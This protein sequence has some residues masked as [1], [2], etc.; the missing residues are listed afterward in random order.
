MSLLHVDSVNDTPATLTQRPTNTPSIMAWVLIATL[1]GIAMLSWHFGWGVLSN[2]I[3]AGALGVALEALVLSLRKRPLRPALA[4]NSALLSGVLLGAALPPGSA[5]WLITIGM[6]AAIIVAKHLYGGL[7]HNVFNPAMVGY[8]LLLVSFPARMSLW[9]P[10]SGLF[11]SD[12][13]SLG[14]TLANVAGQTSLAT[15]DALSGA[16][17]LDA[18]NHKPKGLMASEFWATQPLPDGMLRAVQQVSL[19][20]FIGGAFLLIKGIIGWRIPLSLLATLFIGA[21]VMFA[22]DPS[23]QLGPVLHLLTGASIFGAFFIATDPVS[24]ATSQRGKLYYGIGIGL[25]ILIIRS[26]GAYPEGLAFAVLLMNLAAPLIDHY[27]VPR[28]YGHSARQDRKPS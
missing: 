17:P 14:Q 19:A 18:F 25:L 3:I 26:A 23:H 22:T 8:A 27:S 28:A 20:W 4:D 11:G 21:S 15:L 24:A 16:T 5:W 13:I 10:A 2:I 9:P 7:G 12:A 1:P 6:V